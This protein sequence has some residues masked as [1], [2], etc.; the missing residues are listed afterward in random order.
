MNRQTGLAI[1]HIAKKELGMDTVEYREF[2]HEH[3]GRSSAA[4][5]NPVQMR[6]VI[7]AL[8]ARGFR[9][10]TERETKAFIRMIKK[11]WHQV[12]RAND[13]QLSLR[14]WTFRRYHVQDLEE[15]RLDQLKD[16]FE[17]LKA[18]ASRDHR[19]ID[20]SRGATWR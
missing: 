10:E 17:R 7:R 14:R 3:T 16:A 12:S 1:V 9:S 8:E 19:Y 2:L 11:L 20:R 6:Q 13:E 4:E 18:P 5:L 15:L